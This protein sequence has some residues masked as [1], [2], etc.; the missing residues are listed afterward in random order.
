MKIAVV[1]G[2]PAGLYF[3]LL[4]RKARPDWEVTVFEQNRA[5][6][7]FGFGVVFSDETLSE[8]LGRDA[9]SLEGFKAA[10]TYWD[11]II[12]SYRGE[13]VRCG[14]N[15]FAGCSRIAVLNVLQARC[16]ALG[17]DLRFSTAIDDLTALDRFDIV[18]AADGA[19]S[20]VRERLKSSFRP[21][22]VVNRNKFAWMG[23]TRPLDAFTYFFRETAAGPI[24]AHTYQYQPGMG[25]WV[26]EMGPDTWGALGFAGMGEDESARA[27]EGIFAEELQ[28]HSLIVNRSLW[29]NFPRVSCSRW[30]DGNFVL[31]GDAKATAHYSIG[32]GTKLAMECAIA[33]S[34]A[35]VVHA[36]TSLGA[37][38][39][40]YEAARRTPVEVTQHNADVSMAW[41]EHMAR[42][43]D[44]KPRQ[45]A[46]VVMCRAKSITWD[47]LILRDP[48]FVAGFEDEW[49]QTYYEKSGFDCRAERPGPMFT[50]L[51]LRGLTLANRVVVSPMAQ[52]RAIDGVPNDWHFAH[53]AARAL[54]GAGLVFTEMTC[55][56]AQAR[57]SLGCTGLWNDAQEAGWKRIV[58][59]VHDESAAA[60]C[61]Q[62]GH[63][64]AKG[65]T[66]LGWEAMDHPIEVAEENW[67]LVAASAAPYVEGRNA[68]PTELDRAGMDAVVADFVQAAMRGARAGFDMLELHCGH[69][70]LL[71]GFLSPLTNCRADFYGGAVENRVRFPLEVFTAL[72]AVWPAERP[73]S[74]RI[75]ACDW[76]P[77]G[78]S[79]EDVV[80]IARAFAAAGCDLVD[81]SAGQTVSDQKPVYGRM[82]Q[83]GFAEAVRNITGLATMA[84]GAITEPAQVNTLIACRRADLVALGRPHLTDPFF[85]RR[86][87]AW[88]GLAERGWQ[89]PYIPG[90][91]Q[92]RREAARERERLTDL[93]RKA[94][95]KR[96][97]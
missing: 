34:D 22:V 47:N 14:G 42:S 35:L 63:A 91:L 55:P 41:F 50:P 43:F 13:E 62:L 89:K 28:G 17:V 49:Y 83:S 32:S 7:T 78:I 6:D 60:I 72:R 11:D 24:C 97:A 81:V 18:V 57:I 80:A 45:F 67:P 4:T 54:G 21:Q 44:M 65:S 36:E 2:G 26:I 84:V 29:R 74:V 40:A 59:F 51:G 76:A 38:F 70:Y 10:F 85:T 71:A 15:G 68:V 1:G 56:S 46:M 61:L 73:M 23:S 20:R 8:F 88:Y 37:A 5:D 87:E 66:Q 96:W 27:L 30:W 53:Y 12:V 86:A 19:G 64:G 58:D 95:P 31:L 33:L 39:E 16:R 3:A 77:G 93:Q 92:S 82:F 9:G 25:T 90:L 69:G 75:S 48:V 79:E 52:Y 94:K